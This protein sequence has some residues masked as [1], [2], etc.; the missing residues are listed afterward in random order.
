MGI[1][2]RV[3]DIGDL[4]DIQ[5][6]NNKLFEYEYERFD[7]LLV[8]G[9]PFSEKGKKYFKSIIEEEIAL[10]AVDDGVIIGYLAGTMDTK[11]SCYNGTMAELDNFYIDERYRGNGLG[12]K[13]VDEFKK[14]C[15][16]KGVDTIKVTASA[17][18]SGAIAFYEKNGFIKSEI[19]LRYTV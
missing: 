15:K 16:E 13:M 12:G 7:P 9:W 4:E 17:L 3:A 5:R 19:T 18:N 11:N 6:L 2:I 10:V 8:R 14:Y 1:E